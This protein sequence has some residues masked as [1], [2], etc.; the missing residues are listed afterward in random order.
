MIFQT[1]ASFRHRSSK[2]RYVWTPVRYVSNP[3]WVTTIELFQYSYAD[4]CHNNDKVTTFK[5]SFHYPSS[6][7]NRILKNRVQS[8]N[9][10]FFNSLQKL[11]NILAPF[12]SEYSILMLQ[13]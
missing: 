10:R 9:N 1:Q 4:L 2:V 11:I 6:I 7:G 13:I 12:S 5:N 8:G 3:V